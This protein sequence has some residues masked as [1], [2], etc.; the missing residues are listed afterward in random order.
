MKCFQWEQRGAGMVI[1]ISIYFI[2]V[3]VCGLVQ[4]YTQH[5][6]LVGVDRRRWH[7]PP[8][9]RSP[10]KP[11]EVWWMFSR[12]EFA[13]FLLNCFAVPGLLLLTF[14]LG[15]YI[16]GDAASL[17]TGLGVL[18][19]VLFISPIAERLIDGF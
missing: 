7:H 12:G 11:I 5:L 13:A 9:E 8:P 2:G 4:L 15:W 17:I 18:F 6:R 16:G 14:P 3:F 10:Y 19:F 1:W